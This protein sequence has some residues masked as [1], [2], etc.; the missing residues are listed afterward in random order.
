MSQDRGLTGNRGPD[1][2]LQIDMTDPM[3][4]LKM[5]VF[6]ASDEKLQS[7]LDEAMGI[8]EGLDSDK[9]AEL[10]AQLEIIKEEI[11]RR[12]KEGPSDIDAKL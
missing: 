9:Q 11:D 12:A 6:Q 8:F 1:G 7:I 4:Q 3:E 2:S 5:Q 10:N